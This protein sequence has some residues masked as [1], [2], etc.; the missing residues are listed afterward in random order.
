MSPICCEITGQG[1]RMASRLTGRRDGREKRGDARKG[2]EEK[3]GPI[4]FPAYLYFLCPFFLSSLVQLSLSLS[5]YV[6]RC[7]HIRTSF[8][9]FLRSILVDASIDTVQGN[10]ISAYTSAE[11]V[12]PFDRWNHLESSPVEIGWFLPGEEG[13]IFL[14]VIRGFARCP[15]LF[16]SKHGGAHM[17]VGRMQ[18]LPPRLKQIFTEQL[19]T[20]RSETATK[21]TDI[22]SISHPR[23]KDTPFVNRYRIIPSVSLSR[24]F[25]PDLNNNALIKICRKQIFPTRRWTRNTPSFYFLSFLS[26]SPPSR[27]SS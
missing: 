4:L 22:N 8:E 1:V 15:S 9:I 3:K 25:D 27:R 10:P 5:L 23:S 7:I 13:R 20:Q 16:D 14:V 24:N 26:L 6:H 19:F 11:I 17:G 12:A 21:C 2:Q 18:R